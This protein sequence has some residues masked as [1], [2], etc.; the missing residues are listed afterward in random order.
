ML[1]ITRRSS[2]QPYRAATELV[3]MWIKWVKRGILLW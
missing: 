2:G 3:V 1:L